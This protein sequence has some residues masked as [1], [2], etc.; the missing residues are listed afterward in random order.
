MPSSNGTSS[1][2]PAWRAA[3]KWGSS[4]IESREA[5]GYTARRTFP[6]AQSR[7]RSGPAKLTTVRSFRAERAMAATMD[8]GLRR[9]PQPPIPMVMPSDS[10]ATTSSGDIS[11]PVIGLD[12]IGSCPS[13]AWRR[14]RRGA[15]PTRPKGSTRT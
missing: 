5:N 8:I 12:L 7:P 4:A 9:L 10:V 14:R 15:H 1:T 13:C 2:R 6:V 11:L 3:R